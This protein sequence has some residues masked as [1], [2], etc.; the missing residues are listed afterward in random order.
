[1]GVGRPILG[2]VAGRTSQ[3]QIRISPEQKATLKRSADAAGLSVSAYVLSRALPR[4]GDEL[5]DA[6]EQLRRGRDGSGALATL[7]RILPGLDPEDLDAS[8]GGSLLQ[9]LTPLV[10]N[11]IAALVEGI[12]DARGLEPPSWTRAIPPLPVPHFR[13]PLESLRPYQMRATAPA[14]RRRNLFDPGLPPVPQGRVVTAPAL[15]PLIDHLAITESEVEFYFMAGTVLWQAFPAKPRSAH[16]ADLFLLTA[17]PV[18]AFLA[19]RGLSRGWVLEVAQG[20]RRAA[21]A[22]R[23]RIFPP[24]LS[25]FE[26]PSGYAL[27]MKLACLPEPPSAADV[28][29]LRFL[30]RCSSLGSEEAARRAVAPYIADRHLRGHARETLGTLFT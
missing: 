21:A 15:E 8:L 2:S 29:D 30:L 27:A 18:G 17:D 23:T 7:A 4:D 19:G 9:A 22:G 6:L 28:D 14:Y 11:R 26:P 16:P 13:W 3:L 24:R 1:M 12:L 5:M 20:I 10:Q 25:G